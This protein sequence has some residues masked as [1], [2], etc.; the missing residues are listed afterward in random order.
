MDNMQ[1]TPLQSC[2]TQCAAHSVAAVAP[3]DL[4][5]VLDRR[6]AEHLELDLDLLRDRLEPRGARRDRE[7]RLGVLRKPRLPAVVSRTARY[8]AMARPYS[9]RV[10]TASTHSAHGGY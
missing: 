4:Q 5:L 6:G 8:P 10:C 1:H 9:R 2:N 3:R 7:R